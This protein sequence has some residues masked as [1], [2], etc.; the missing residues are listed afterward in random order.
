MALPQGINFR[1]TLAY[2]SDGTSDSFENANNATSTGS[3]PRTTAQ[4]NTVGWESFNGGNIRDRSTTVDHRLS[5]LHF[6]SVQAD[7]RIDLPSAGSYNVRAAFGDM[8][9]AS[10]TKWSLLDTTTTLV[11][12]ATG[13][14]SSAGSFKDATDTLRTAAAWPSSNAAVTQTFGTT[15]LRVRG[16]S[17]V[18][19]NY[20]A[21]V[22]VEAASGG[23]ITGTLASTE[24][25]DTLSAS[26]SVLIGGTLARTEGAD[27]ASAAGSVLIGGSLVATE[28]ADTLAAS[29][30]VASG[31]TG[32]MAATE[33][34]DTIAA[35]GSALIGG[36]LAKTEGADTLAAAGAVIGSAITG[37]LAV[38][39]APDT[40]A[41]TNIVAQ[42]GGG[43]GAGSVR[44]V[45]AYADLFDRA[46]KPT[47]AQKKRIKRE[48]AEEA[49]ELLPDLPQSEVIAPV[50]AQLVYQQ[51]APAFANWTPVKAMQPLP[52]AAYDAIH[53]QVAAFLQQIALQEEIEDEQVIELLLLG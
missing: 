12:L 19:F 48:I 36:T 26:G 42:P 38:T 45:R 30:S 21:H 27:T 13:T 53:A 44:D 51:T 37:T 49:L 34:N 28:G 14:N 40:L 6:I 35:A 11:T 2:V 3:Y 9:S 39:E 47:K 1:S 33:G 8:S 22:Y 43:G 23:G 5:G 32:T 17:A 15:I 50:I 52:Q 4:G 20:I 41:A 25:G 31:I 16:S 10:D 18:T 29:G 24:G 46:H 7:Y